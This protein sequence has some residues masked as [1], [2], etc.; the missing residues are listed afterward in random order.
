MYLEFQIVSARLRALSGNGV[1]QNIMARDIGLSGFLAHVPFFT[2]LAEL[3][4][5]D[6]ESA[7]AVVDHIRLD[8][9]RFTGR[10]CNECRD[11]TPV[12]RMRCP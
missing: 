7:A 5:M 8:D 6:F 4:A 11:Q 12:E 10:P 3:L 2:S 1:G 9:V